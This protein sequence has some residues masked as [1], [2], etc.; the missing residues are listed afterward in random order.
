M[1]FKTVH[2]YDINHKDIEMIEFK[3][4]NCIFSNNKIVVLSKFD[5]CDDI[6]RLNVYSLLRHKLCGT[7]DS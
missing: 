1:S 3:T 6:I 2:F 5:F 7:T 4:L